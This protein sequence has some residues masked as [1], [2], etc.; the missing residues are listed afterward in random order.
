MSKKES[1]SFNV[2][3]LFCLFKQNDFQYDLSYFQVLNVLEI[4]NNT[5]DIHVF[6]HY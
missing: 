2:Q 6:L 5:L 4:P 3:I 1:C